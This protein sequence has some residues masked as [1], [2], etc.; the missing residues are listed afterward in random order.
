MHKHMN[1]SPGTYVARMKGRAA[2][3]YSLHTMLSEFCY[4]IIMVQGEL[5]KWEHVSL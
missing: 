3:V 5:S 1:H 4:N 2:T